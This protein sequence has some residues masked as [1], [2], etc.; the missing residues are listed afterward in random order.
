MFFLWWCGC[1]GHFLVLI[2]ICSST[3]VLVYA[4]GFCS[5]PTTMVLMIFLLVVIVSMFV[6]FLVVDAKKGVNVCSLGVVVPRY[7]GFLLA[8]SAHMPIS[9]GV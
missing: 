9:K 8:S 4:V 7:C 2:F 3:L 5:W 1:L 6:S